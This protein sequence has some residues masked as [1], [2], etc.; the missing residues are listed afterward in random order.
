VLTLVDPRTG[1]T[2]ARPAGS[3]GG[4]DAPAGTGSSTTSTT[5]P[6]SGEQQPLTG[7]ERRALLKFDRAA[8]ECYPFPGIAQDVSEERTTTMGPDPGS[9]TLRVVG[10]TAGGLTQVFTWSVDTETLVFTPLDALARLV[11]DDCPLLG[12]PT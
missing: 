9:L 12:S 11:S 2:F 5:R 4:E 1:Q 8:G 7:V 10:T 6:Q 3:N